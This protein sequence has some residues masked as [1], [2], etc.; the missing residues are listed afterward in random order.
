MEKNQGEY[1]YR[2]IDES[3]NTICTERNIIKKLPKKYDLHHL[4][5]YDENGYATFNVS[6]D[7]GKKDE[8]GRPIYDGEL[9]VLD[10]QGKIVA[11]PIALKESEYYE[12]YHP[13]SGVITEYFPENADYTL[14]KVAKIVCYRFIRPDGTE[15]EITVDIN[16]PIDYHHS[17]WA[18]EKDGKWGYLDPRGEWAIEPTFDWADAFLPIR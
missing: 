4:S 17:L 7:T 9:I 5:D 14:G 15:K 18:V 11:G 3:M 13:E 8:H 10:R 6:T 2:V 12:A 1:E 16:Y